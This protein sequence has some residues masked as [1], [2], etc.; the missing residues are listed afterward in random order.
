MI[1]QSRQ[2]IKYTNDLISAN[3]QIGL[4]QCLSNEGI[5]VPR[6]STEILLSN[7]MDEIFNNE[8]EK[9]Q[10][11]VKCTPFN[12]NANN[13]TTSSETIADI[14]ESI[15]PNADVN[16]RF[17]LGGIFTQIGD[18]LGGSSTTGGG[19]T[20]SGNQIVGII[21]TLVVAAVAITALILI[22]KK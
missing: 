14:R 3:N 11:I 9:W 7:L 12:V 20:T 16:T 18:F 15:E 17:D 6:G 8:P 1:T 21:A 2:G 5:V 4:I 13:W 22:F 10:R 19:S